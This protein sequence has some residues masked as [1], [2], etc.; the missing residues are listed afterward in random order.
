MLLT[1]VLFGDKI[2]VGPLLSLELGTIKNRSPPYPVSKQKSPVFD[3]LLFPRHKM[4]EPFVNASP[5]GR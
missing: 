4:G 5:V 2:T 3:K 1:A